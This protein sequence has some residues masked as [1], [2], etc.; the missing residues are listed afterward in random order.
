MRVP[1]PAPG[2]GEV[3]GPI[4]ITRPASHSSETM[5]DEGIVQPFLKK[6]EQLSR[7]LHQK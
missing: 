1:E 6:K 7:R 3:T 2:S 5:K 4:R